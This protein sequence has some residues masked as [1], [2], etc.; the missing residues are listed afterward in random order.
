MVSHYVLYDDT[1]IEESCSRI[2][3]VI[4]DERAL[5]QMR[6]AKGIRRAVLVFALLLLVVAISEVQHIREKHS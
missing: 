2:L 5:M 3:R 4:E 6:R 1:S